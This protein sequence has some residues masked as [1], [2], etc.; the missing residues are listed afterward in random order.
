MSH[1]FIYTRAI[2]DGLSNLGLFT[3]FETG[4]TSN[5][6]SRDG[7]KRFV[8]SSLGAPRSSHILM[9]SW[10]KITGIRSWIGAINSLAEVVTS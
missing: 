6:S 10:D 5:K 8:T 2:Q 3:G 9:E 1:D 4:Y 7:F